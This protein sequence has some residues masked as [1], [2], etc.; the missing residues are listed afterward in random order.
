M[1][2]CFV[3]SA[4][5]Q[6]GFEFWLSPLDYAK[7]RYEVIGGDCRWEMGISFGLEYTLNSSIYSFYLNY[8][9]LQERNGFI[10][11]ADELARFCKSHGES[12]K[13]VFVWC[14]ALNWSGFNVLTKSK[15]ISHAFIWGHNNNAP[16][17]EGK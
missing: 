16:I 3:K 15:I 12:I 6:T 17:Q 11:F 13:T 10:F 7:T 5:F 14:I 2:K 4:M 1:K 8:A 9:I